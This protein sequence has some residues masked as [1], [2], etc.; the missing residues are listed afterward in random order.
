MSMITTL[1]TR[2]IDVVFAFHKLRSW[3]TQNTRLLSNSST[4]FAENHELV[5][6]EVVFF[7]CLA[8]DL[9]GH[10]IAVDIGSIPLRTFSFRLR[11]DLGWQKPTHSVEP[12]VVRSLQDWESLEC[13]ISMTYDTRACTIRQTLSSSKTH[14]A[15]A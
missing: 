14:G 6:W 13:T 3:D 11:M 2:L 10:S 15:H 5:T 12:L 8:D 1:H 4:A 9:L 7:D